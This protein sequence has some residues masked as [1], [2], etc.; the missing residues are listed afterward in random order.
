MNDLDDVCL[1]PSTGEGLEEDSRW[2]G[3]DEEPPLCDAPRPPYHLREVGGEPQ[4]L[5]KEVDLILVV[6]IHST[7]RVTGT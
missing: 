4:T 6:F 5:T 3:K 7:H 2:K 1:H